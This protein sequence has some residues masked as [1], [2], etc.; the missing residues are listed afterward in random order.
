MVETVRLTNILPG[1]ISGV[2]GFAGLIERAMVGVLV[3]PG[4]GLER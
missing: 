1:T 4:A 3:A 2:A